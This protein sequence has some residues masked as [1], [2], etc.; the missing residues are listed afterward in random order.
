MKYRDEN[1]VFQDL[2]LPPS[3]DTLPIG[4]VV[5]Y[6]G[7]TVPY[8]YEEYGTDDYSTDE[9]F[10]GRLWVNDKPL[11]KKTII[12]NNASSYGVASSEYSLSSLNIDTLVD[13]ESIIDYN[14]SQWHY[15]R[16]A[17]HVND[18]DYFSAFVRSNTIQMRV[19]STTLSSITQF[20]YIMHNIYYTKTTD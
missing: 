6:D 16:K 19:G 8:G 11:Y 7:D 20:N 18:T 3:G 10:T 5:D 14:T 12:L 13:I 1:G 2:Y 9:T 15:T 4:T 17:Y